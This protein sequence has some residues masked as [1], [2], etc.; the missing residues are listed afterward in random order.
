MV[1]RYNSTQCPCSYSTAG[2][3]IDAAFSHSPDLERDAFW[4]QFAVEEHYGR[5]GHFPLT[6]D[7]AARGHPNALVAVNRLGMTHV[8]YTLDSVRGYVLEFVEIAT[9]IAVS[10]GHD[11]FHA[12]LFDRQSGIPPFMTQPS[13]AARPHSEQPR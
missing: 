3:I 9:G 13:P 10:V 6:L 1:R 12:R 8:E 11:A 2:L 5:T 4:V 7:E